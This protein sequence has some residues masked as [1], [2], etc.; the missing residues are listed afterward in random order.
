[1]VGATG[2]SYL[3]GMQTLRMLGGI[4]LTGSDGTELDSLLR[5]PKS[6]A[7]LAYL[8]MP[9]PGTWHRRDLLLATF[10]PELSQPRARA[11][12]RSALHLLRRHLDD[13]TIRARGDEEVSLDPERIVTDV[14]ALLDASAAE[15][16]A[17]ALAAYHGALLPGLYINDAPEFE[18][19]LE[20][21]RARLGE[22]AVK[23]AAAV[24]D[25]CERTGDLAAAT[26]A[27]RRAA[28]LSPDDE[29]VVRR[30][31]ALLDRSGDRAQALTVFERLRVRLAAEFGAEPSAATAA[32]AEQLRARTTSDAMG[33]A[34]PERAAGDAGSALALGA[35]SRAPAA[36]RMGEHHV[37]PATR[38]S[39]LLAPLA[40]GVAMLA[41]V[42]IVAAYYS[43]RRPATATA[44]G[45]AATPVVEVRRLVMLPVDVEQRDTALDYVA[46]GLVT[47]VARRL[48]RIGGLRLR[49]GA[50]AE[51]PPS[52]VQDSSAPRPIGATVLLRVGVAAVNDSLDVRASLADSASGVVRSVLTRRFAA[53]DLAEI[54]SSIAA[55]V[56][57]SIHRVATPFD[58]RGASSAVDPESYR[59]TI[60]GFHQLLVLREIDAALAS[61]VRATELDP[62]NARAW[63]GV[64]SIWATRT[65]SDQ[66]PPDEG[67][68]RVTAAAER[69]L[70]IDSTDGTALANLG[71]ARA[72]ERRDLSAGLP[73]IRRAI[74]L[75][76]SNAESY[77]V[78]SFLLRHAHRWDEA[79]DFIRLGHELDPLT[80][81]YGENEAGI[82]LCAGR[83]V[84]SEQVYRRLLDLRPRST[85]ASEGLVRALAAQG[86]WDEALSAWREMDPLQRPDPTIV[87][88]AG[89][90]RGREGYL[91]A[92]HAE[93]RARLA[94]LVLATKGERVS[95]RGHTA[96]LFQSGDTTAGFAAL[97]RAVVERAVWLHRMPCIAWLDEVRDTPHYRALLARVGTLP[98]R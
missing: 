37:P 67:Y 73:L 11:A 96:Y 87:V 4:G 7:L 90:A 45:T 75:E 81:R 20:A 92:W 31:I 97:E 39:A 98:A 47:G 40:L 69:A 8:A 59:L 16:H 89:H 86:R 2:R 76:P 70:A 44:A 42:A 25:A 61:L 82:E 95:P 64:S 79:R 38:P 13:D 58:P 46:T 26:D 49:R 77:L 1:M 32:L 3:P 27:A 35:E 55:T 22:L 68:A 85:E 10:W 5:Q 43:H 80:P 60:L 19:W 17:P 18:R 91:A 24:V 29:S 14:A 28:Q 57:G 50:L 12:L 65:A 33:A 34:P 54:E 41:M 23:T 6:V 15:R 30:W 88:P 74:E 56:A 62:R 9:R 78:A 72:L 93:G 66:V 51:W 63:A 21:E 83:P 48:E 71:F 52:P 36:H 94:Q 84:A 53:R